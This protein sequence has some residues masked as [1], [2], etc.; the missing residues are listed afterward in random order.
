VIVQLLVFIPVARISFI[1][2]FIHSFL[3]KLTKQNVNFKL[4][5]QKA[6]IKTITSDMGKTNQQKEK[7]SRKCT[8]LR[9][10]VSLSHTPESLKIP[11]IIFEVGDRT[12]RRASPSQPPTLKSQLAL[13]SEPV[14]TPSYLFPTCHPRMRRNIHE[15][16]FSVILNKVPFNSYSQPSPGFQ[17]VDYLVFR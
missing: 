12:V 8:R 7:S 6:K 15:L 5:K 9:D 14:V 11:R 4:T 3:F 17:V 10:P 16:S 2:L 13:Y 1:H